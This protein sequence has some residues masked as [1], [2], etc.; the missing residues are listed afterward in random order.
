MYHA[1]IDAILDWH[2]L[3]L[4]ITDGIDVA[5]LQRVDRAHI[6]WDFQGRASAIATL[7]D[8]GYSRFQPFLAVVGDAVN[9]G[10]TCRKGPSACEHVKWLCCKDWRQ[11]EVGC[12]SAPIRRLLRNGG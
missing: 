10:C 7:F 4:S 12:R 1:L 8:G 9:W 3:P 5:Y 6:N 11:S 2:K